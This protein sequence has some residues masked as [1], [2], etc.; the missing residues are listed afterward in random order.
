MSTISMTA[1]N[2]QQVIDDRDTLTLA[3]ILRHD[4]R[5][6]S[7][8]GVPSLLAVKLNGISQTLA[9]GIASHLL[10]DQ[11]APKVPLSILRLQYNEVLVGINAHAQRINHSGAAAYADIST[12]PTL[13]SS[14]LKAALKVLQTLIDS[15]DLDPHGPVSDAITTIQSHLDEHDE[16][17]TNEAQDGVPSIFSP[18]RVCYICKIRISRAT[19]YPEYPSLCSSCGSFNISSSELSLPAN[20]QLHKKSAL[21][22]GGRINLGFHTALRLLRCGAFVIVTTRY[23]QDAENRYRRQPDFNEWQSRLRIIG[24]D[25]RTSGDVFRLASLVHRVL[26]DWSAGAAQL[27]ILINNA[28]QTLTD[29][30]AAESKAIAQEEELRAG[31]GSSQLLVDPNRDYTPR[32]R[33]GVQ[34]LTLGMTNPGNMRQSLGPS[35][36]LTGIA[37]SD[38]RSLSRTSTR[39]PS[40]WTQT[41]PEIPY[42]DVISAH[43]V[44]TF[45]PLILIRELLPLMGTASFVE[46]PRPVDPAAYIINVS[47]REGIF[48]SLQSSNSFG[49]VHLRKTQHHVH[50]NMSKAA[51]N[52]ITETEAAACWHDKRVCMNSVDPG[53]MSAAPG[54]G[55]NI[56]L[57]WEDGAGRVLWPVA[58]GWGKEVVRN[59]A[60]GRAV[61]GKFLKHYRPSQWGGEAF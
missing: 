1:S 6:C 5:I 10:Q 37:V 38:S 12:K 58:V 20:L 55:M 52:M 34:S 54:F 23:P 56:P 51:L 32:V 17:R 33:G 50:T 19:S 41:L 46:G 39:P 22:T 15:T 11:E 53:Y 3:Q 61:W 49:S 59:S 29:S 24:A 47:S 21:V 4:Q 40:S 26:M 30:T 27:D 2:F 31:N 8:G 60:G 13:A 48:D 18:S 45:V 57:G 44:N 9:D 28:A 16:P 14:E 7:A 25:F 35:A 43:S 42:E 36:Q